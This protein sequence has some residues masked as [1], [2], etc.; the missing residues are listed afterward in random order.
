ML[1]GTNDQPNSR[2]YGC[3]I[4]MS[5]SSLQCALKPAMH[6]LNK[7]LDSDIALLATSVTAVDYSSSYEPTGLSFF[8]IFVHLAVIK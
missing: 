7:V 4:C 8:V 3:D 1:L 6:I 2:L 5:V